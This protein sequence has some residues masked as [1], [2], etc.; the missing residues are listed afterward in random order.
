MKER[1]SKRAH[2]AADNGCNYRG[3]EQSKDT[4]QL[5]EFKWCAIESL[6]EPCSNDG[7]PALATAKTVVL[8]R[9]R[10]PSRLAAKVAATTPM[11]TG[12]RTVGPN[13]T[14]NPEATPAAGQNTA[15]PSVLSSKARLRR[16]ARKKTIAT[17]IEMA[18]GGHARYERRRERITCGHLR[19]HGAHPLS[20]RKF[21]YIQVRIL[22]QSIRGYASPAEISFARSV[23]NL[24]GHVTSGIQR[25]GPG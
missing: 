19:A 25:S 15:M 17:E 18:H 21:D 10:S 6:D 22:C 13:A 3:A 16:A 4:A 9:L 1:K 2:E 12:H 24:R 7:L 11:T 14:R 20:M 23:F 5:I 8:A